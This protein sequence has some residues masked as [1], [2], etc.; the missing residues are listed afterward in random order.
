MGSVDAGDIKA[1]I[2]VGKRQIPRAVDRNRVKR[3]LRHLLADRLT[4]NTIGGGTTDGAATS[5]PPGSRIVVRALGP[6]K[7]MSS[8]QLADNLDRLL[9]RLQPEGGW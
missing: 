1:G 2:I 9:T 6:T 8:A 4:Q 5:L 3:R 7:K